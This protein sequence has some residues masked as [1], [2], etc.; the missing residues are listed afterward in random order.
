LTYNGSTPS[1]MAYP[2]QDGC[3]QNWLFTSEII[4]SNVVT[5]V[6]QI[7]WTLSTGYLPQNGKQ[8]YSLLTIDDKNLG[9][10]SSITNSDVTL[11]ITSY[12][13]NSYTT[14]LTH[15]YNGEYIYNLANL[16]NV[17]D[18]NVYDLI[19]VSLDICYSSNV[20]TPITSCSDSVAVVSRV[21][22]TTAGQVDPIALQL[23]GAMVNPT[24][25]FSEKY[26]A[27]RAAVVGPDAATN[28]S[29][30]MIARYT[31][32]FS[33]HV[34]SLDHKQQLISTFFVE[35]KKFS[36]GCRPGNSWDPSSQRCR[37]N[38]MQ[39][40]DIQLIG[41][42]VFVALSLLIV[43]VL[44]TLFVFKGIGPKKPK[45]YSSRWRPKRLT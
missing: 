28:P 5:W 1:C 17:A 45:P 40:I 32:K 19:V 37:N 15:F 9:D 41:V 8:Y 6:E 26:V 30:L 3:C 38:I 11:Q 4:S 31:Y 29:I 23:W 44:A 16:T 21:Y 43:I 22:S 18:C 33:K 14:A 24:V 35:E 34:S 10:S 7:Q 2:G 39:G 42:G 20:A 13:D 36:V 27:F 25:C 12:G